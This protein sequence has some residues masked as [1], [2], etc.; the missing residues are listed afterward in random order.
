MK[1]VVKNR[2]GERIDR[3]LVD[4]VTYSRS[5]INKMLDLGYMLNQ[6]IK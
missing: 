5:T 1:I 6:V 3:Y 2:E 4:E